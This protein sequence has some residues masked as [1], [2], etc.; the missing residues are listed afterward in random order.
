MRSLLNTAGCCPGRSL[1]C[2]PQEGASGSAPPCYS[3][4][5]LR[6][7]PNCPGHRDAGGVVGVMGIHCSHDSSVEYPLHIYFVIPLLI[8]HRRIFIFSFSQHALQH[9]GV[10]KREQQLETRSLD[11][12]P[13]KCF[14]SVSCFAN[15]CILCV[16]FSPFLDIF[17]S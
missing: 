1:L 4:A 8:E 6:A 12:C 9:K 3:Q 13:F 16:S 11:F 10:R 2:K 17:S 14:P 5:V 15:P 7:P